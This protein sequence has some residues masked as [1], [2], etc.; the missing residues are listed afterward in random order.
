MGVCQCNT[1]GAGA[2]IPGEFMLQQA[3]RP[4]CETM[5]SLAMTESVG[6]FAV[7]ESALK[8]GSRT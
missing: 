8:T 5:L 7:G 3:A 2:D 6:G 1:A 4:V